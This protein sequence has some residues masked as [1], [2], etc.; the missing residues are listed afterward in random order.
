M[1]MGVEWLETVEGETLSAL[2][3]GFDLLPADIGLGT[4]V[5]FALVDKRAT[6]YAKKHTGEAIKFI[7]EETRDVLTKLVSEAVDEGWSIGKLSKAIGERYDHFKGAR[8]KMIARTEVGNA[9]NYGKHEHAREVQDQFD[10]IVSKTWLSTVGD[11]RTREWHKP[12][13]IKPSVTIP[14]DDAFTVH[15]KSMQR[16]HDEEGGAD[17][18][19][20]CRCVL[21]YETE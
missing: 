13:N 21:T 19:I 8:S 20:N 18:V 10:I 3:A 11:E 15:D 4:S 16:P 7:Q 2:R 12:E 17:N 1:S 14:M 9:M 5:S 6:A